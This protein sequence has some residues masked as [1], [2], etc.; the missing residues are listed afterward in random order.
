M[1]LCGATETRNNEKKGRMLISGMEDSFHCITKIR[2]KR[3]AGDYG[4][5]G[6]AIVV[7]KGR[8]IPKLA[9][10]T[11]SDEILWIEL[12]GMGQ[13]IFVAVVYLVPHKSSRYKFNGAVRRELEED[14]LRF[15]KDGMVVVMGDLNS[16]IADCQ[17]KE[18]VVHSN[19]R[20]N[21]D[22]KMNDNGK[23]WIRLTRNTDMVTLTGLFGKADYTC[24]NDQ[25]N[26]VPDH[27]C[28]DRKNKDLIRD[29]INQRE[30]MLRIDT[31]HSMI[32]ARVR[33]PGWKAEVQ[34][35]TLEN[36]SMKKPGG[37][38]QIRLNQIKKKEVWEKYKE[39]CETNLEI[40]KTVLR[41]VERNQDQKEGQQCSRTE[42][43]WTDVKDLVRTLELCATQI[44]KRKEIFILNILTEPF[45]VTVRLRQRSKKKQ[46]R[47]EN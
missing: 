5:G 47:G 6:L 17:P 2:K 32:V 34:Q 11:G 14:I 35:R 4:S 42:E 10:S 38:K 9:K 44:A 41:L 18:G 27:I 33:L 46:R 7:R 40:P 30:V 37:K 31:D 1:D 36:S 8:G 16:R 3:K 43:S 13:K 24:F 45:R 19:T 20:V 15:K 22:K 25:G 12:E 28:I 39:L 21:K 29:Y 26:S 23:A